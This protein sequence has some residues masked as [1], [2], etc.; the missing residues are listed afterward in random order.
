MKSLINRLNINNC[1]I[2]CLIFIILIAIIFFIRTND[3]RYIYII[4]FFTLTFFAIILR[5]IIKKNLFKC[6]LKENNFEIKNE[7]VEFV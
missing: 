2:S 5:H 4:A 1:I 6:L 3:F 7:V